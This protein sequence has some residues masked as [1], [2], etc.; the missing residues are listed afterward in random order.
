M[1]SDM[2]EIIFQKLRPLTGFAAA[3]HIESAK[4]AA[5]RPH[6]DDERNL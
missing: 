3:A 6:D 5:A 1:V 4:G 2:T